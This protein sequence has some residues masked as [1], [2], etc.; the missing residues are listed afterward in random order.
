MKTIIAITLLVLITFTA[1]ATPLNP[2]LTD[3]YVTRGTGPTVPFVQP[4]EI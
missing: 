3:A 1:N 4:K 2:I